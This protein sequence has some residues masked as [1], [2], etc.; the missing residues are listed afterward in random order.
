[1]ALGNLLRGLVGP[2][3]RVTGPTSGPSNLVSARFRF[4]IA[5]INAGV[6]MLAAIAAYKYRMVGCKAIA[7]G[8]AA[9]TVTTVDILATQ[10]AASVK[11]AAF[12]QANLDAEHGPDRGRHRRRGARERCVIRPERRQ[13]RDHRQQDRIAVDTATHIDFIFDYVVELA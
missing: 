4:T 1:M 6:S 2:S 10:G 12:A 13:H 3:G 7:I 9:G 11:L 8:G 5:Q